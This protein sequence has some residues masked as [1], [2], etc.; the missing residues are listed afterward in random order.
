MLDGAVPIFLRVRAP[1]SVLPQQITVTVKKQASGDTLVTKILIDLTS[2]PKIP[3]DLRSAARKLI[4]TRRTGKEY[5]LAALERHYD[6]VTDVLLPPPLGPR[7][8]GPAGFTRG[9]RAL[10]GAGARLCR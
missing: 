8:H 10:A 9:D 6:Y 7:V 4:A 2:S 1:A 5:M 3:P